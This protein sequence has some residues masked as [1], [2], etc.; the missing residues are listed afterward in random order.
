MFNAFGGRAG[1]D[2]DANHV[3]LRMCW[4]LSAWKGVELEMEELELVQAVRE[5][6]LSAEWPSPPSQGWE[7]IPGCWSGSP[8]GWIHTDSVPF[9]CVF[10]LLHTLGPMTQ[11]RGVLKQVELGCLQRSHILPV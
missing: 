10:L 2:V 4:Q 7:L 9:K 11:R 8:E 1:L 5:D 6:F 3:F